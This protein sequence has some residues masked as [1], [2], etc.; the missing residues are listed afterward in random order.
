M[1]EDSHVVFLT[2][3]VERRYNILMHCNHSFV[4]NL[5]QLPNKNHNTRKNADKQI[6]P[7]SREYVAEIF[8]LL[9]TDDSGTLTKEEFTIV[10]KILYSQVFTRIVIQWTL[11]LMSESYHCMMLS[12]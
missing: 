10:M 3:T 9:D 5:A 11:T 2:N 7:A 12:A 6:Q 1:Q 8:H 4:C